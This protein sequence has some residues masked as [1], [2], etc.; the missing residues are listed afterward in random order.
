MLV[1]GINIKRYDAKQLKVDI[2]P[3]KMEVNCEW[4]TG[5]ALPIEYNTDVQ[6]GHLKMSVYF[7]G[8]DRNRIIR[9]ASEF[10]QNFKKSCIMELDGYK[11]KYKG[12]MTDSDYEKTIAKGRYILNLEFDGYFFDEEIKSIFDC[13]TEKELY[14]KGTRDAPCVVEVT[15]KKDL[16]DYMIEGL[17]REITIKELQSGKTLIID[18]ITGLIT[19]DG[20]SAISNVDIW[21]LPKI[22]KEMSVMRF[23]NADA[24][25]VIRY[26][27]MWI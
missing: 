15:A 22:T 25:V 9:A 10:M 14:R 16:I 18:G 11:G 19:V 8:K 5:A 6:M 12:Y 21:E 7:R 1:N 2:Q 27:P 26:N 23:P 24:M 3:P 17:N 20:I 13:V 4:M